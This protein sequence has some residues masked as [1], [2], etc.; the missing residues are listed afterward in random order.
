MTYRSQTLKP[1][2]WQTD[3]C[4]DLDPELVK[5]IAYRRAEILARERQ[6]ERERTT[7]TVDRLRVEH[8][9]D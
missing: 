7:D 9:L 1:R 8:R 2:P 4:L 3:L 5:A 6:R